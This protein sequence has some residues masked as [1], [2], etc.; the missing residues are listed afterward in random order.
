MAVVSADGDMVFADTVNHIGEI[1]GGLAGDVDAVSRRMVA[2]L[3]V[4]SFG[5]AWAST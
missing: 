5:R 3:M 4:R 1:V 2:A